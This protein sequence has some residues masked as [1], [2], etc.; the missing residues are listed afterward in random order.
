MGRSVGLQLSGTK[1]T[2]CSAIMASFILSLTLFSL[3]SPMILCAPLTDKEVQNRIVAISKSTP[4][5]LRAAVSQADPH[6]LRA[7]LTHAE[8]TLLEKALTKAD[9]DLLAAALTGIDEEALITALTT[10][11]GLL[12]TLALTR[13][14]SN[15]LRSAPNCLDRIRSRTPGNCPHQV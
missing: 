15:L 4:E 14:N 10:A 6:L 3:S 12:L 8:P 9:P 13:S 1:A 5:L 11:D 2:I 7:A